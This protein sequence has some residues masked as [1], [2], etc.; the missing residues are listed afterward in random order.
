VLI[1]FSVANYKSIREKQTFSLVK[2]KLKEP[3]GFEQNSGTAKDIEL[4]RSG[5]IYGPNAAGKSNLLLA[6]RAMQK[7]IKES[8]TEMGRGDS[9]PVEPYRLSAATREAATEF[10]AI[11]IRDGV[12]YQYGFATTSQR[13]TEEWLIAFPKGRPQHWFAREWQDDK[14]QWQMGSSLAGQK[15]LWQESTRDNALFLSTAIQLN[16]TQ[17]QPVY[18]WFCKTLKMTSV[19]GWNNRYTS[20]LCDNTKTKAKILDFLKAADVGIDDVKVEKG[21]FDDKTLP[22]TIPEELRT[23]LSQK[24]E[25]HEIVEGI[26]TIHQD[27]D[28]H[29]VAFDID[30][31]SDGT[32]KLF[33]FAGPWLDV[34]E[35]GYV[36]S[37]DE[38]HDNLHPK[39]VHFLVQLFHSDKTNPN[40]A[41]L[42]FTT[43]DTSI[44]NSE[45][46]R[47][48]QI[49]F[50]EKDNSKSTQLFPLTEFS[51]RG[52]ENLEQA[53]LDGRYGALPYLREL[54]Q[55]SH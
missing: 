52:R 30:D 6:L 5:A 18:D 50:C 17:L 3:E 11:F 12:R 1:E 25:G 49:W 42:I 29:P 40:N 51:P 45:I 24:L 34:L 28:G 32:K 27:E 20:S 41:Q 39:L 33:A 7:I 9:I 23:K 16:S 10:E 54:T 14:Y 43:H 19:Q 47:R 15:Q 37:V 2:S 53:Y 35:N 22:D 8:A 13:I 46:F 48:D 21:T 38:L 44:L 26:K 55:V 31:E 36:L 4:L